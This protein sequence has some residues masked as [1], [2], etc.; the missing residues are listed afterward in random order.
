MPHVVAEQFGDARKAYRD[1]LK[2]LRAAESGLTER[3]KRIREIREA[4]T[5][6]HE[7]WEALGKVLAQ[8]E[9]FWADSPP[10][11]PAYWDY[12]GSALDR[13][14]RLAR[15]VAAG[16]NLYERQTKTVQH[17]TSKANEFLA[18]LDAAIAEHGTPP[19]A[20][21]ADNAAA[22]V[23]TPT[24]DNARGSGRRQRTTIKA[25]RQRGR[26]AAG[27][28]PDSSESGRGRSA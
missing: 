13:T 8:A 1:A 4:S 24:R 5:D 15:L 16:T 28:R 26:A 25:G 21:A 14:F 3:L 2:P 9:Y 7:R 19:P 6:N 17:R 22:Q 12:P 10:R 20:E 11:E 23:P 27:R 18:K